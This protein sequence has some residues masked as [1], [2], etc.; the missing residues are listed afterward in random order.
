MLRVNVIPMNAD[1]MALFNGLAIVL[2]LVV[3]SMPSM[4][5][6]V[7][8]FQYSN[9]GNNATISMLMMIDNDNMTSMLVM[10][11]KTKGVPLNLICYLG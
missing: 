7:S 9:A 8:N 11:S 6:M 4:L 5:I 3:V 1:K 10:V 2:I